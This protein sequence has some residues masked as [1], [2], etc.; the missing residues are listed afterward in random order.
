V[1]VPPCHPPPL[2]ASS[3]KLM[4]NFT[5]FGMVEIMCEVSYS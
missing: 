2:Q 5:L 3:F 4:A 1:V